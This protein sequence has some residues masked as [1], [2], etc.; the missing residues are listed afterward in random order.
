MSDIKDDLNIWGD[1]NVGY[2][3]DVPSVGTEGQVNILSNGNDTLATFRRTNT[4]N[5]DLDSLIRLGYKYNAQIDNGPYI[6]LTDGDNPPA[7]AFEQIGS[8]TLANPQNGFLFAG[9]YDSGGLF[10]VQRDNFVDSIPFVIEPNNTLTVGTT[11]N[12][13]NLVTAI[14]DIPNKGY[15]DNSPI[16]DTWVW[17]GCINSGN[18]TTTQ[19]LR[20]HNGTAEN[21]NE[22]GAPFNWEIYAILGSNR[23]NT[24]TQ[25]TLQVRVNGTVALSLTIQNGEAGLDLDAAGNTLA[26]NAFDNV[27]LYISGQSSGIPYPGATIWCRR[28]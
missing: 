26:I 22:Y 19:A 23:R 25:W 24:N 15:V 8:G 3:I 6:A 10:I 4:G 1:V 28:R 17:D 18:I 12:Y 27:S 2:G 16:K 13:A 21:N 20:R 14:N 7:I 11:A 9:N 5:L